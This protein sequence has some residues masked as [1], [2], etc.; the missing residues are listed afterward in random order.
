MVFSLNLEMFWFICLTLEV[1]SGFVISVLLLDENSGHSFPALYF[2]S[3]NVFVEMARMS[4]TRLFFSGS[5]SWRL[6]LSYLQFCIYVSIYDY[7]AFFP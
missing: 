7:H 3:K 2:V 4:F 5:E 1:L 6:L